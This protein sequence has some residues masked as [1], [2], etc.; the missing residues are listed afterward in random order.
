M[1]DKGWYKSR[2]ESR[3]AG[4]GCT[5]PR[6]VRKLV[7]ERVRRVRDLVTELD[8]KKVLR[9]LF[10]SAWR[11]AVPRA[12]DGER[13][14]ENVERERRISLLTVTDRVWLPAGLISR[15]DGEG[16]SSLLPLEANGLRIAA[17][18]FCCDSSDCRMATLSLRRDW[19]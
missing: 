6:K 4:A 17:C 16:T 5:W 3:G 8:V 18:P 9:R 19:L 12:D 1:L 2:C 10:D 11:E 13:N 15:L 7:C 14:F